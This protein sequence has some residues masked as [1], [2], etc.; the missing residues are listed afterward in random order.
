MILFMK[1]CD[2]I[3]DDTLRRGLAPSKLGEVIAC[4]TEIEIRTM[5]GEL[6]RFISARCGLRESQLPGAVHGRARGADP[7]LGEAPDLSTI[8]TFAKLLLQ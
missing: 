8:K 3:F 5:A 7:A 6:R 1:S 2:I 4:N